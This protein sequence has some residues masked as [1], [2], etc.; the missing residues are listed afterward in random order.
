MIIQ[1]GLLLLL[2]MFI[3]SSHCWVIGPALASTEYSKRLQQAQQLRNEKLLAGTSETSFVLTTV[4]E[5]TK[6]PETTTEPSTPEEI[7]N[8]KNEKKGYFS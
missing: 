3:N 4:T 5:T 6:T 2:L 1:S 7:Q 8:D